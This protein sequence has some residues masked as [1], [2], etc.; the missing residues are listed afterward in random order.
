MD[1]HNEI[2]IESHLNLGKKS[3][4][5]KNNTFKIKSK[6]QIP[7]REKNDTFKIKSKLPIPQRERNANRPLKKHDI[8]KYIYK[9]SR[10]KL[11]EGTI[12]F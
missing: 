1:K 10:R 4:G 11:I 9:G 5:E 12:K 8:K 7:R 2:W 3:K 6:L